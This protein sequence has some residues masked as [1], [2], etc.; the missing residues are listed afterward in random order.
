MGL[1][2]VK[3]NNSLRDQ[4]PRGC[5]LGLVKEYDLS[6]KHFIRMANLM[7]EGV[8]IWVKV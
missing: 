1:K 6:I 3:E 4:N 5:R 8:T 2:V 7:A